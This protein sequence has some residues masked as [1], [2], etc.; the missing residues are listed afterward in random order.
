MFREIHKVQVKIS[1]QKMWML[2]F[3]F[4][5]LAMCLPPCAV[6]P[7]AERLKRGKHTH[8]DLVCGFMWICLCSCTS[9]PY[10]LHIQ[11]SV[12]YKKQFPVTNCPLNEQSFCP[13]SI[14][15]HLH[16]RCAII[17]DHIYEITR[18]RHCTLIDLDKIQSIQFEAWM[19]ALTVF[20]E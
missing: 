17:V 1:Y 4:N 19:R 16:N 12:L 2:V 5:I 11:C 7:L 10:L 9:S 6:I 8:T 3:S 14:L 20:P 18:S 13:T 15:W